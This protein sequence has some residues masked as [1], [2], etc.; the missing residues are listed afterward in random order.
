MD[1]SR[2]FKGDVRRTHS[3]YLL[4][5]FG[6]TRVAPSAKMEAEAP[7]GQPGRQ[8]NSL[9]VLFDDALRVRTRE[10]V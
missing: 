2:T 9:A 7:I 1:I 4:S 6:Q 5:R 10:E 3:I 8:A